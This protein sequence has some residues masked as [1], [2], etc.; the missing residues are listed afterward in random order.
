MGHDGKIKAKVDLDGLIWVR[1]GLG[2]LLILL[3]NWAK[4]G[5]MVK[6][7]GDMNGFAVL[8]LDKINY[9]LLRRMIGK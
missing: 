5:G 4:I 6:D 2:E 7:K 8:R 1:I 9:E 3:A